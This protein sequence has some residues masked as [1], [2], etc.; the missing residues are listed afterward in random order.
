MLPRS[1]LKR[2][3]ERVSALPACRLL[4]EDLDNRTFSSTGP[5]MAHF[6]QIYRYLSYINFE[7]M[8]SEYFSVLISS[9]KS[10]Y[11]GM[12]DIGVLIDI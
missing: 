1:Y 3:G 11:L 7:I 12:G 9:Q 4:S 10:K 2:L 8:K 6:V 5:L